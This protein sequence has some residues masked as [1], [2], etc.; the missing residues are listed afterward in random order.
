MIRSYLLTYHLMHFPLTLSLHDNYTMKRTNER[1]DGK[2]EGSV[3]K[4]NK[5]GRIVSLC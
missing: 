2:V 4:Q 1:Q 5:K 3:F